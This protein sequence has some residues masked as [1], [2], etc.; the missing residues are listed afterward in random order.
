MDYDLAI[1]NGDGVE[2]FNETV[3]IIPPQARP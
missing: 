3:I 1:Y 2:Y